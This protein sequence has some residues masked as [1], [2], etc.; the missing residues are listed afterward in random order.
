M[1]ILL[2]MLEILRSETTVLTMY[3]WPSLSITGILRT[4]RPLL[5]RTAHSCISPWQRNRI[6]CPESKTSSGRRLL[7]RYP[8]WR[9][10]RP[11]IKARPSPVLN[12]KLCDRETPKSSSHDLGQFLGYRNPPMLSTKAVHRSP[13]TTPIPFHCS[14]SS[15]SPAM[16]V[17]S[18]I[19]MLSLR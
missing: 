3:T 17:S 5:Y 12:Y 19:D 8:G 10:G 1:T 11:S 15:L 13:A 18:T 2:G 7:W 14:S 16:P 6:I 9:D 4:A